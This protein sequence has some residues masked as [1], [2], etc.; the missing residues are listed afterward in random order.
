M[1][2]PRGEPASR[3]ADEPSATLPHLRAYASYGSTIDGGGRTVG[4]LV[5]AVGGWRP[6]QRL[7]TEATPD[8]SV[9]RFGDVELRRYPATVL[10]ETT[11][12][13]SD[14]AVRRL[15][16]YTAGVNEGE[17]DVDVTA[18]VA[19]EGRGTEVPMTVPEAVAGEGWTFPTTTP[20]ETPT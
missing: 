7:T 16:R 6:Y 10:A 11:A 12:S 14:E 13:C 4:G 20:V 18:P 19:V 1:A 5:A 8:T 15:F 9:A 2:I 17:A 3:Q